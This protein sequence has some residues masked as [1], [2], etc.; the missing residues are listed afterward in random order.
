M[1]GLV[2]HKLADLPSYAVMAD[3]GFER[4][5]LS[6]ADWARSRCSEFGLISQL[7][8]IQSARI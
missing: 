7:L 5:S 4:Q 3:T 8:V 6:A 2:R 1:L